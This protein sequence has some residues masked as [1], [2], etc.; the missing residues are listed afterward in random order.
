MAVLNNEITD[1][2]DI[3]LTELNNLSRNQKVKM[4]GYLTLRND[5]TVVL[6]CNGKNDL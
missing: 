3:T 4:E 2:T 5:P 6:N 1:S